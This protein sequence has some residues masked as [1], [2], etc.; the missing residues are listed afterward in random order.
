MNPDRPPKSLKS[1]LPNQQT[2]AWKIIVFWLAVVAGLT[3][4]FEPIVAKKAAERLMKPAM[5]LVCS[6]GAKC[7]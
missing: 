1:W 7:T 6:A 5:Q 3:M 4:F 2:A